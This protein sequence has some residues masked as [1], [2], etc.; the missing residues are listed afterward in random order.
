MNEEP[1]PLPVAPPILMVFIDGLGMGPPDPRRNPLYAGQSS[2]L[3]TLIEQHAKPVDATLGV[4]GLPQSATGQTALLTGVNAPEIMGRHIEGFPG[5]A[6][7][8]IIRA[9]NIFRKLMEQGCRCTFANAY[10]L[11]AWTGTQR[12]KFQSVTTVA[13]LS[14][15]GTVRTVEDMLKGRAVYQDLTRH[16]LKRRGF[17]GPLTTPEDSARDLISLAGDFDFTLFE[18]F[19]TDRCG[20]KAD[21]ERTKH[22][23]CRLDTFLAALLTAVQKT[24][25][26]LVITSDHGNI[27]DCTTRAHTA[28]PVPFIALGPGCD[29]LKNRVN[30]LTDF[31]PALLAD[32]ALQNLNATEK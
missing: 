18:Y 21:P 2:V 24:G 26:Q 7:K 13:A 11:E 30:A 3:T 9:H 1:G 17:Q 15:L 12:R 5:P 20:H 23:L 14:A 32:R 25:M 8:K 19:Q 6:L 29:A 10:Y 27:E 28:N 31:V 22:T 4:P 16:F